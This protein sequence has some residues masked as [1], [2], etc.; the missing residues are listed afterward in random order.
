MAQRFRF[1]GRRMRP[2]FGRARRI[3]RA[4]TGI[5]LAKRIQ[6]DGL[7]IPDVT[8]ASFDNILRVPLLECVE[9]M[10]E[11]VESNGTTIADAPLYSRITSM[12]LNL[13]LH[14]FAAGSIV[15][16]ILHKEPDGEQAYTE[17]TN[18]SF[19]V[20]DDNED[21]RERRK[22]CLAKGMVFINPN[23]LA[24]TLRIFV[25]RKAWARVS[26]LR[27]LD[28]IALTLAK[29]AAGTTGNLSGFGTLMVKANA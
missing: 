19:H 16:W 22:Y 2:N 15:R 9:T 28:I 17:L 4:V 6:L 14:G 23:N 21:N 5:N 13:I 29:D 18:T 8:S 11:E 24:T 3:V 26:P 20:S 12:R 10:D 25:K 1:R 7:T 27:E